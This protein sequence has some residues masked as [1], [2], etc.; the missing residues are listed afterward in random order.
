VAVAFKLIVGLGNPTSKYEKTRH[1]AGFWLLDEIASRYRANF[2]AD[3]KSQGLVAK[4]DWEGESVF[5]LKPMQYM[6]R[7]GSA[8]AAIL[9]FYKLEPSRLLVAHDELDLAP[10]TGRLKVGGGHGGHNG[11]RDI[12]AQLGGADFA[13]IRLGIGHPGHKDEVVN[14]VLD[15]PSKNDRAL[16]DEAINSAV[17]YLPQIL[18]GQLE[19]AMNILHR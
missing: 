12:L 14:Y 6:N 4:L 15:Q 1:N 10:G 2:F 17:D 9:N 5:L 18:T 13:R 16:L 7:S 11:L 19:Q 8:V 3:S